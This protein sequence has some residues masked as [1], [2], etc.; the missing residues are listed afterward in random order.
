MLMLKV[1]L[2]IR[3]D[4]YKIKAEVVISRSERN[5]GILHR[6]ALQVLCFLS[7]LCMPRQLLGCVIARTGK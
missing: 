3:W 6:T 5:N 4:L 1:V 7:A 2:G